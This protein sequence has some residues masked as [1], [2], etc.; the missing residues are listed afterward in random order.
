MPNGL[1]VR[2]DFSEAQ[3]PCLILKHTGGCK[4]DGSEVVTH[5]VPGPSQDAGH[6]FVPSLWAEQLRGSCQDAVAEQ[7][8]SLQSGVIVSCSH[9]D[10]RQI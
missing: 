7:G 9:N 10:T 1:S 2:S 3:R 6:D 4:A 5:Q 8:Q